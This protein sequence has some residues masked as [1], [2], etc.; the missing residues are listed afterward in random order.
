MTMVKFSLFQI[1]CYHR[2]SVFFFVVLHQ[3]LFFVAFILVDLKGSFLINFF[4]KQFAIFCR[5]KF[6]SLNSYF[7]LSSLIK[8]IIFKRISINGKISSL[9]IFQLFFYKQKRILSTFFHSQRIN[10]FNAHWR[11]CCKRYQNKTK[12]LQISQKKHDENSKLFFSLIMRT[13]NETRSRIRLPLQ[14]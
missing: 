10:N 7:S 13:S 5:I 8:A 6:L 2:W 11:I 14:P 4:A 1:S 12:K 3:L 9:R